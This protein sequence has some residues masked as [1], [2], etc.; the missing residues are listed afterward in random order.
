MYAAVEQATADLDRIG[1][2]PGPDVAGDIWADI[3]YEE[4]HN[5]TAIEGNTL[6]LK[7]V[8]TLLDTGQ[9]VGDKQLAEYLEVRGYA[10]AAEWVYAQASDRETERSGDTPYATISEVREI[11]R[12]VVEPTW[13]VQP[14]DDLLPGETPGGFRQHNIRAFG[15]GMTPPDFTE[16]PALVADW[17]GMANAAPGGELMEHLARV[18]AEFERI[19]PF[20]DGNGRTGRLVLNLLLVRHGL[21]P[22]IIYKK[23]RPKY[24]RALD[25][26]DHGDYG[27]LGELFARA[28]KDCLDRF[29]LPAL[30]GPHQVLPLSALATRSASVLALRRAAERNA[31]RAIRKPNGWYST[32]TWVRT[33]V[34]GR[35]K[36]RS[37]GVV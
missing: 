1:G 13:K 11:H 15:G 25:R 34:R 18:H 14:P 12:L 32:K 28:V 10:D 16:I 26:A 4:T 6:L 30:G 3:W 27:P 37:K 19:H 8:Q 5:S 24:L 7:Q 36:R 23:D 35:P 2:L 17:V 31:L 29:L 21:A 33:Y 20:R 22:A 9:A